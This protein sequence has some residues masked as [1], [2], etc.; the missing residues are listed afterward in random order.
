MKQ[1]YDIKFT[2]DGAGTICT[3]G[4]NGRFIAVELVDGIVHGFSKCILS[5]NLSDDTVVKVDAHL[6]CY[7]L[8]TAFNGALDSPA[9]NRFQVLSSIRRTYLRLY[10]LGKLNDCVICEK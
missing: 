6:G 10:R 7:G 1:I 5:F 4:N 9:N 3:L 2:S 8:M